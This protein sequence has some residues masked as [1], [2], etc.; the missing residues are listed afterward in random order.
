MHCNDSLKFQKQSL[1]CLF[2]WY[3]SY[4]LTS[5]AV[6][7][8]WITADDFLEPIILKEISS[9]SISYIESKLLND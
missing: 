5:S 2:A 9:K 7:R 6:V 1:F 3:H 8:T 4:T